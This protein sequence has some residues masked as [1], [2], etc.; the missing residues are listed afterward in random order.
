M[1]HFIVSGLDMEI[2]GYSVLECVVPRYKSLP[3]F[4]F[5]FGGSGH[6]NPLFK[7][8]KAYI[9]YNMEHE[10]EWDDNFIPI[11]GAYITVPSDTIMWRGFD[12]AYPAISNR[13]AYY[14]SY[15]FAEGYAKKHGTNA[16][17]F[18]TS[19]PLKLLDIRYMKVLL[20]QLFED[21]EKTATD[22]DIITATTISF[23]L[24]SLQ[25][26]IKLF[27][28]RYRA[29]YKSSA[30]EYDALKKGVINLEKLVKPNAIIEQKGCRIAETT[31]DAIVMG[32]LKELFYDH[33]DGYIAPNIITHFHVEKS[34][35]T[36]NSEL[37][38]FDPL[39]VGI[40]LL[41]SLPQQTQKLTINHLILSSGT[42]FNTIDTRGMKTF[43]YVPS[44]G[45][46]DGEDTGPSTDYN[47]EY[48]KG[49]KQIIKLFKK[50]EQYGKRWRKKSVK[51]YNSI[52]PGPSVDPSI[53]TNWYQS[54]NYKNIVR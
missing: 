1:E 18:I 35:L 9:Y 31:N 7:F 12:P 40:K 22:F 50:G 32:F 39:N 4:N 21:N 42:N 47:H 23:G 6:I 13:P 16:R 36:L 3:H 27:K 53:F 17:A 48:D 20:S 46:E 43:F 37:V 54:I 29:I 30:P 38:V 10:I 44:G 15:R 45:G 52:A 19:R 24:C 11:Y 49:N 33:Y 8:S 51:L 26:Q 14:G 25:H 28:D 2:L 34:N 41:K 5:F